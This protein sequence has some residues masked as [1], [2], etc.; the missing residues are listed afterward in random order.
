MA[1]GAGAAGYASIYE[2]PPVFLLCLG[3]G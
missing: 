1:G 2:S 3:C